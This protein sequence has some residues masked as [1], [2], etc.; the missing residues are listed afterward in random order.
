MTHCL[1]VSVCTK[2]K[3]GERREMP[4]VCICEKHMVGREGHVECCVCAREG[5]GGLNKCSCVCLCVET[6]SLKE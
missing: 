4:A 5:E 6:L 1:C 2:E 3:Q